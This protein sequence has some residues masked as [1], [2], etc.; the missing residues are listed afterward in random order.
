MICTTT[1][2]CVQS[3]EDPYWETGCK[4]RISI[5]EFFIV[6]SVGVAPSWKRTEIRTVVGSRVGPFGPR[7]NT[8]RGET[9]SLSEGPDG[10]RRVR[11]GFELM[12]SRRRMAEG[13]G[14]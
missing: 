13:E 10:T 3:P 11:V 2:R 1:R 5:G 4:G 9:G 14:S 8:D 6:L 12:S 7:L